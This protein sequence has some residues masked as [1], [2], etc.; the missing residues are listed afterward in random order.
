M[1]RIGL[2]GGSFNPVHTA[3][4]I[5]AEWAREKADLDRVLFVPARRPPHKP[6]QPLAPGPDRLEMLKLATASH[7]D[8]EVDPIELNKDEPSYTL[9][10][11][12]ALRQR[13]EDDDE[14]CLLVG[15]DSVRDLPNWWHAEQLVREATIIPMRRP[16]YS[17]ENLD[18]LERRFGEERTREIRESVVETPRLQISATDI[19]RR[20][21][22]GRSVR[23][24]VPD[25]VRD[26]ILRQGIYPVQAEQ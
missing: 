15:A 10:T 3:H 13:L 2:F 7:P 20:V 9:L 12:R 16:G 6:D 14:L 17:L 11:V 19:R 22:E 4:L 1:N 24:L 23:Y 26:Y 25:P 18:D 8:F 5:V 21:S